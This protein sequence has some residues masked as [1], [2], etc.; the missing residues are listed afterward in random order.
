MHIVQ[1]IVC[2]ILALVVG[3]AEEDAP[4]ASNGASGNPDPAA[5][6]APVAGYAVVRKWPHDRSAWTQG[7]DFDAGRLY[8]GTGLEGQS[9]LREIS[10]EDATVLRKVDLPG[11]VFGEGVTILGNRVYQVT[12]KTR[13]G[14]VYDLAS[15]R[16]IGE[17]TYESEGWGLTTD[18]ASL[19][20]SDG[21][22]L[23][24]FMSPQGFTEQRR[25]TVRDGAVE[26][27]KLN[28]L[29]WVNGQVWANVWETERI[30]RIDPASGRV[31][32][33][34]DLTGILQEADRRRFVPPGAETSI[35]VL[36]GIAYDSA[37]NRLVVTGKNWPLLYEIRVDSGGR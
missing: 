19:I 4:A 7:L 27:G 33:W 12:W 26:V 11:N 18:G 6:G 34:I 31:L 3:C 32:G 21:T 14:F 36:N 22:A 9:T 30:V 13:R 17:F 23:L 28:E 2:S 16:R 15:F 25:V 10:L 29:E 8:E 35:D 1:A 5:V 37:S 24:R 20:L